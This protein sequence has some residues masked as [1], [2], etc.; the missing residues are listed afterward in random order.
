[1][2]MVVQPVDNTAAFKLRQAPVYI[3]A[4]KTECVAFSEK[5]RRC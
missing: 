5:V 3:V 4:Q 1:M 2:P